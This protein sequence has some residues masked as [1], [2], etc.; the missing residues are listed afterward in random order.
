MEFIEGAFSE[1]LRAHM[2]ATHLKCGDIVELLHEK[3][4]Y[5]IDIKRLSDYHRGIVTPPFA[6]AKAIIDA[7]KLEMTDADLETA[8]KENREMIRNEKIAKMAENES[9]WK[10]TVIRLEDIAVDGTT[11][12]LQIE[13]LIDDRVAAMFGHRKY[14]SQYV[15]ELIKKDLFGSNKRTKRR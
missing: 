14:F 6:K 8:L 9:H 11:S 13:D 4:N 15:C 7:G 12:G 10:R 2:E 3:G 1:I 5:S